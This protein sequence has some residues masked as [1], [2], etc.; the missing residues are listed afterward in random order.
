MK[1]IKDLYKNSPEIINFLIF[2]L[3]GAI[4][5]FLTN[6]LFSVFA[7]FI[8]SYII[9]RLLRP[10]M[11]R[12]RKIKIPNILCTIIC[13]VLF[14]SVAGF[15]IWVF[16]HYIIEGIEYLIG[17]LSSESAINDI[18]SM[19]K[20]IGIKL[21]STMQFL[22]IEIG[23]DELTEIITDITKKLLTSLSNWSV[24]LATQIPN[25]L[26]SFIIGCV[27]AF[28]MLFDYDKLSSMI[29][30]QL[31]N[32]MR[33][34]IHVINYDVLA[35]FIK[36]ILSYVLISTVCFI[37]LTI[38]FYILGIKDATFIALII[39]ILDVLPILGSG[40]VLLPWGI[41]SLLMGNFF[42]GIGMLVLWGVV[43]IVRQILEPKIVGSQVGLHPL[44]TLAA[45]YI[46]LRLMGGLGLIVGPL[47]VI[48]CKKLTESGVISLY[49]VQ[50]TNNLEIRKKSNKS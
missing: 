27:A 34:F 15:V 29:D 13:M 42:V 23:M 40:A 17:I 31:S 44:L 9:M 5:V 3:G 16:L 41:I 49:K 43:T 24:S 22:K 30:R 12:L 48:A 6:N 11:I 37:E 1:D 4:L 14:A 2:L 25:I 50:P 32:K 21:Q 20:N 28:Y 39:A 18:V 38:G 47:Y 26:M 36:M 46:G 8:I 45:L 19:V 33:K 10:L 7:P 35:S